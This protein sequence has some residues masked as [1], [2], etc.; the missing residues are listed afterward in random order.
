[1]INGYL[2]VMTTILVIT[3]VIRV[4]QN[5]IRLVHSGKALKTQL[6]SIENITDEDINNQREAYNLVVKYLSKKLEEENNE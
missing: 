4:M 2:A 5:T 6:G 3:Q 1:M